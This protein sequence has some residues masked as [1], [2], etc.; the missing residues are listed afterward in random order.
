MWADSSNLPGDSLHSKASHCTCDVHDGFIFHLISQGSLLFRSHAQSMCLLKVMHLWDSGIHLKK[1]PRCCSLNVLF[2]FRTVCSSPPPHDPK[3]MTTLVWR[4]TDEINDWLR[5]FKVFSYDDEL[6]RNALIGC[7]NQCSGLRLDAG[8]SK[9][10]CVHLMY[11]RVGP[12][13]RKNNWSIYKG[14]FNSRGS[15]VPLRG[16][17]S[18]CL[19]HKITSGLV[20]R[21]EKLCFKLTTNQF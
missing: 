12:E 18:V 14:P 6:I 21:R 20:E 1:G 11:R 4:R 10:V 8:V 13:Q 19:H 9:G 5:L 2:S 15:S 16:K 3:V 17:E 7:C